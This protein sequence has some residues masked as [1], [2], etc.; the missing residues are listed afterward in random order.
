MGDFGLFRG[1]DGRWY[2]I[3][4]AGNERVIIVPPLMAKFARTTQSGDIST[5]TL[6]PFTE[7]FESTEF[8]DDAAIL[9]P[10]AGAATLTINDDGRFRFVWGIEMEGGTA[11]NAARN[12]IAFTFERTGSQIGPIY[13]NNYLRDASGHN[14]V[15]Q[16][17]EFVVDI[18]SGDVITFN[19]QQIAGAGGTQTVEPGSFLFVERIR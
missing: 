7:I 16:H 14:E 4:S 2:E 10:N 15:S 19:R 6:T 9:V 1:D 5:T 13:A 3:D 12:N 8:N 11:T 18:V 17:G